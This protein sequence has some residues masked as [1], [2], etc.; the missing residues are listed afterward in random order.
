MSTKT[1]TKQQITEAV[2]T[3]AELV[4]W[5][6]GLPEDEIVWRPDDIIGDAFRILEGDPVLTAE[7]AEM[8]KP[9]QYL[10]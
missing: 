5:Q 1:Y 8:R 6:T 4:E 9:K 7:I 3:L 2:Q 10:W